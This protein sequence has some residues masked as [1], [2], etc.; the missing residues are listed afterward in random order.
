[1]TTTK[2][3]RIMNYETAK[4]LKELGWD[5]VLQDNPEKSIVYPTLE[6]LIEAC[7]DG[8]WKINRNIIEG[9]VRWFV[10]GKPNEAGNSY[11]PIEDTLIEAVAN[12]YIKLNENH[13]K[14]NQ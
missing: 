14:N 6:Q 13:N 9:Q 7:G 5:I 1:M 3:K 4:K 8:L 11:A 2:T 12:L 10:Y